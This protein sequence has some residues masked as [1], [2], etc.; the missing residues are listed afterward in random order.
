MSAPAPFVPRYV[1]PV[2]KEPLTVTPEGL[3]R[4]D[5]L[6]YHLIPG[7]GGPIADFVSGSARMQSD[8]DTQAMYNAPNSG[9]IYR[10]FLDWLFRTFNADEEAVRRGMVTRMRLAP[11]GRA[12]VTGCGLGEDLV[13]IAEVIGSRGELHAQ[14]LSRAM[15]LQ[16]DRDYAQRHIEPV[17]SFS[18]GDALELPYVDG[19]FDAVLHFGGIN[20]FGDMRKAVA[21]MARVTRAG[22]RVVF[23]DEGV[24]PWLR[25]TEYAKVAIT[26]IPLWA[27]AVPIADLPFSAADVHCTWI[28]GNCFYLIDFA[29]AP[30]GPQ[31]NIDVPHKGR[32]GGTARSRYYGQLEGVSPETRRRVSETAARAGLSVHDWLEQTLNADMGA[33]REPDR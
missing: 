19:Y 16:A 10:N 33:P 14:D 3:R 4:S 15:V 5:G 26:N 1:C 17:A 8:K 22:G 7:A 25:G 13:F 20:L 32:R 21:E 27:S 11:G 29:I 6:F 12:L 9:E 28:L 24:A 30:G 18:V 31:M 23:G 2:T